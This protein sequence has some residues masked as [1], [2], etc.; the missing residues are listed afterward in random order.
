MGSQQASADGQC[1]EAFGKHFENHQ[2]PVHGQEHQGH[3]HA[4]ELA[5]HCHG[6]T[7]GGV[8]HGSEG[9]AHLDRQDLPG[10]DEGLEQELQ[11]ETE[12]RTDDD[13][14]G[15]QQQRLDADGVNRRR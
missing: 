1:G 3:Q 11:R 2:M 8:D 7:I 6:N 13:L 12:Q 5:D 10:D 14:L 9:H 15:H 4:E